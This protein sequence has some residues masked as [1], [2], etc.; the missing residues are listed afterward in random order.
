MIFCIITPETVAPEAMLRDMSDEEVLG[1]ELDRLY[2][3]GY[4]FS[5]N[6]KQRDLYTRVSTQLK[7]SRT[8]KNKQKY[9]RVTEIRKRMNDIGS[10][11]SD[12]AL[13]E[14]YGR[15]QQER[16]VLLGA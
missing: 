11:N 1:E 13:R 15:L 7:E 9:Q 10:F 12:P 5:P 4:K 16:E 14:E 3:L 8:S 2:K 6:K